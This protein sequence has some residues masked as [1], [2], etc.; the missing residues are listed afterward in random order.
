MKYL[1]AAGLVVLTACS[2]SR[3]GTTGTDDPTRQGC[4]QWLQAVN[5]HSATEGLSAVQALS[6]DP[7][8]PSPP[9]A[10]SVYQF[11]FPLN[12]ALMREAD[13]SGWI[14]PASVS[15][16]MKLQRPP[17][18]RACHSYLRQ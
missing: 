13:P 4:I 5:D 9:I 14:P 12:M 10:Y 16:L 18:T 8:G 2:A 7:N 17:L 15:L 11:S 3:T 6:A 1:I